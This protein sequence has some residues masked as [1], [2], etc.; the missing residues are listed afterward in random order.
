[1]FRPRDWKGEREPGHTGAGSLASEAGSPLHRE[2]A[3]EVPS[4]NI[5]PASEEKLNF[6]AARVEI[7]HLGHVCSGPDACEW[8]YRNTF[9]LLF[10]QKEKPAAWCQP[11]GHDLTSF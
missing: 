11:R 4:E 8:C 5:L 9:G 7:D 3:E 10:H 6:G 1:M 2:G